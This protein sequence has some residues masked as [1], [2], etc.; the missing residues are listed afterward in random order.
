MRSTEQSEKLKGF[1]FKGNTVKCNFNNITHYT[2]NFVSLRTIFTSTTAV[3]FIHCFSS[4]NCL[5]LFFEVCI[6][7]SK[8]DFLNFRFNFLLPHSVFLHILY[9]FSNLILVYYLYTDH[10]NVF[11]CCWLLSFAFNPLVQHPFIFLTL[12]FLVLLYKNYTLLKSLIFNCIQF[13]FLFLLTFLSLTIFVTLN[14]H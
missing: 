10:L 4:L 13:A 5:P 9:S 6:K 1:F 8:P 12:S 11:L 14:K 3:S 2:S 7:S